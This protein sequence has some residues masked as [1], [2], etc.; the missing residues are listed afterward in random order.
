MSLDVD[1]L[2]KAMEEDRK[3]PNGY[4]RTLEKKQ[5]LKQKRYDFFEEWLKT[6]DFDVLLSKLIEKHIAKYS[7][8]I[9][10]FICEYISD[11]LEILNNDRL[12]GEFTTGTW[13]FKG[14]WFELFCGQGCYWRIYDNELN[15]LVTI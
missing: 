5:V 12:V 7:E 1:A 11:R 15:A 9:L 3:N 10:S 6:N 14:Y 4:W 8:N 2:I 13:F